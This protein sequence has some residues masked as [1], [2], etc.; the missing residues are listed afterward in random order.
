MKEKS[1]FDNIKV[2]DPSSPEI[3]KPFESLGF[4]HYRDRILSVLQYLPFSVGFRIMKDVD[5]D[6][7]EKINRYQGTKSVHTLDYIHK[8]PSRKK[9]LTLLDETVLLLRSLNVIFARNDYYKE[10]RKKMM[11][12]ECDDI[13]TNIINNLKSPHFK[14]S[15]S[16]KESIRN[17]ITLVLDWLKQKKYYDRSDE[18]LESTLENLKKRYGTLIVRGVLEKDNTINGLDNNDGTNIYTNENDEDNNDDNKI[19]NLINQ[20]PG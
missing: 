9:N 10:R 2:L 8:I 13:C 6:L 12:Y 17:D 1:L 5:K 7:L 14:L 4:Q 18:E 3:N 15:D 11:H 16:N 20:H 19:I